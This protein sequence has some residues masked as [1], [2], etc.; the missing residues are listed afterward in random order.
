MGFKN[1]VSKKVAVDTGS[2][3]SYSVVVG[4]LIDYFMGG[5][6]GWGIVASRGV[7]TGINSVTSGPYGWWQDKWYGILKTVPETRKLKEVFDDNDISHYFEREK[8]GEVAN[9]S[10]RRGK[11][12]LTDMIA[13]NTFEPI[14]YGISNC[15][16][17][18][19]NTGDVDFQQVAEG[20]KAVVYISPL[21]APTM[22]WTMQ[23]ARKI[24]GIKTSAELAKESLENI[25]L[26]E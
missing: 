18:L 12:F 13:F 10:G 5:L 17:Q 9:Y 19:I 7:A 4:A 22:R 15:V 25:V 8:F 14:V 1:D 21:I 24:F 23:G 26:K 11:Q 3:V 2:R 20:M 16:G 6:T